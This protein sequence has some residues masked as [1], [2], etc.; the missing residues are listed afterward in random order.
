MMGALV[1]LWN[2]EK[3]LAGGFLVIGAT[4]LVALGHMQ[5]D[6]WVDYTKWI[7]GIYVGGKTATAIATSIGDKPVATPPVVEEKKPVVEE[8]KKK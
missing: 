6:V 8:K 2:S 1:G 7:F 3:G 5:V 4:L